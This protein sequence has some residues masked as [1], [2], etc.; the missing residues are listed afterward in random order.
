[1]GKIYMATVTL[2]RVAVAAENK[3]TQLIIRL[4]PKWAVENDKEVSR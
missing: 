4:V 3:E 1:M 2:S